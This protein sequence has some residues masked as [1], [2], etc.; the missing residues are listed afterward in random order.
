MS[1]APPFFEIDHVYKRF[2]SK[3]AL[4]D[5][6]LTLVAGESVALL[7]ANG[8]GK[9]TLLRT[10]ATL[11]RPTRGRVRAFGVE[12]WSA[13]SEVRSRIGVV[14]H[15]PYVYPELSCTENLEFFAT[16][17]GLADTGSLAA[18]ALDRVGL[19]KRADDRAATLSRGLLQR[20][21]LARA[22]LHDPLVLVLDEP[23]TGLDAAGREVLS[24]IVRSQAARGGSIVLTTHALEYGIDL[25]TRVVVIA[26][27]QVVL[28]QP[29]ERVS[30]ADVTA[31]IA[32]TVLAGR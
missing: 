9:T 8:A 25:A 10:L 28:D 23:D 13:R 22:I 30:D 11:S 2:G 24:E 18:N 32:G 20:L 1:S 26:D 5:V 4:R 14:A 12:A 7:G 6:N 19:T 15:Q 21:N 31:A 16:M 29:R 3:I 17:F 27:G